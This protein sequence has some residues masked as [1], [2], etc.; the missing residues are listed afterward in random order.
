MRFERLGRKL[1]VVTAAAL[2]GG[3]L[4]VRKAVRV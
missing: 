3:G 1:R 4:A 2:L